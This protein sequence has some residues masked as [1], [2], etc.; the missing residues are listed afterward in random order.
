[1]RVHRRPALCRCALVGIVACL[2]A[3]ATAAPA[4]AHAR[5]LT[6]DPA[7]DAVLE[8]SPAEVRLR[9]SE[10]VETAFGAVRVY[11]ARAR[12][13]DSGEVERP[14][15]SE[16]AVAV[17]DRLARGTYTVT[18]RVVSADAH[19]VSGAFVFHVGAP[20]AKPAGI[21]AEVLEGGT[22]TTVTVLFALV[23]GLDFALILLVAG[24]SGLLVIALRDGPALVRRRLAAL[25]AATAAALALVA[26]AGIVLQ[27]AAAGGFG[28]GEALRWDVVSAV[29]ETRFGRVWFA[30]AVVALT[31]AALL[32][33]AATRDLRVATVVPLLAVILLVAPSASGHASVSGLVALVADVAHV[34]AAAAWAGGLAALVLALLWAREERWPLAARAVPRFSTLAVGAVA[35]LVVAGTTNGYLQVRALRG[36]WDTTYGQL[37]LVKL[38]LVLP[39]LALGAY[40]NRF[41]VPRLKAGIASAAERTR[42]LR[43]AGAELAVMVAVVGVTAVLVAEPPA[44]AQVAPKGPFATTAPFGQLELNLVVDPA[45]AGRNQIHLY[46]TDRAGQPAEVAEATV[47]A[48]LASK[49]IGP[50][51]FQAHRLAPGHLT[52]HSA[53]LALAGDWQLRVQ[54]RRGEFEALTATVSV[55]IRKER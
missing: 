51:R 2:A 43:A 19:P 29:L 42:F 9:F 18:W 14:R 54:A 8:E 40:N 53:Q 10:P 49:R 21:A 38:A 37:L 24:G 48:T 15:A 27:G 30:Q 45:A 46:L 4:G 11:D 17:E 35:L 13:V 31:I 16:V 44:R 34:A 5:L 23:R 20:G 50:L 6:T 28:L 12:R 22:P 3:L 1:M 7:N 47:A 25:L 32:A 33:A 55:P 52:V 39:L 26:L 41:A 36:L